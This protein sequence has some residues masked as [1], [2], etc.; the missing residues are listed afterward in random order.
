MRLRVSAC[1]HWL[2][3]CGRKH[4]PAVLLVT[5]DIDEAILLADR[6]AGAA[7]RP[8]Q[9]SRDR[10]V[11]EAAQSLTAGIRRAA[12]STPRRVGSTRSC[13]RVIVS[14]TPAA[15]A[16]PRTPGHD[17]RRQPFLSSGAWHDSSGTHRCSTTTPARTRLRVDTRR[18]LAVRGRRGGH[19][20]QLGPLLPVD[21]RSRRRTLRMLDHARRLGRADRTRRDRRPGHRWWLPQSGSAGRHGANRRPHQ[22]WAP[23]PRYRC[24]L[25]RE[26]LRPVRIRLR[27]SR[28]TAETAG[29]IP[30]PHHGPPGEGQ[31]AADAQHP[32]P[33]RRWRREEDPAPGRRVR[34]RLAQLRRP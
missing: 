34:R 15:V 1:R 31:P 25:V 7:R 19:R 2:R 10:V 28:F 4:R 13:R 24:R 30:P 6:I 26:G 3:S 9:H 12:H 14:P 16:V 29:R 22:R 32:G 11:R 18:R 17:G 27:H 21:R 33:H 20:L 23:D 8:G 5:H